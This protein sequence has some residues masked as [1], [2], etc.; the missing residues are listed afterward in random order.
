MPAIKSVLLEG[1]ID[2]AGA[3]RFLRAEWW[4]DRSR[5]LV[6]RY[7]LNKEE[8]P[9][10]LRLDLDKRVFLDMVDDPRVDASYVRALAPKILSIVAAERSEGRIMITNRD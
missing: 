3:L 5:C 7:A 8:Q 1:K 4:R 9:L 6:I 10:G 2:D